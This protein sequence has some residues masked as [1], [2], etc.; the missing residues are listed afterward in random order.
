MIWNR[1]QNVEGGLYYFSAHFRVVAA[2]LVREIASRF[3][4]KPGGYVWALLEPAA[5]IGFLCMIFMSIAHKPAL[6]TNFPLFFATGYLAYQFYQASVVFVS[7]AVRVNHALL[8]YPNVAPIDTVV[9]RY[10][11]QF[12][13]TSFIAIV[14]L[15]LI[16]SMMGRPPEVRWAYVFEAAFAGSLLALGVAFF[17]NAAFARFP[18]YEQVFGIVSRPLFL[19]SGVFFLPDSMPHPY[20]DLL[21]YNP[22]AHIIMLFRKGFYPE[23]RAIGMDMGYIYT[24]A[25]VFLFVGLCMFTQASAIMRRK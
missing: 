4:N 9:A 21:L 12:G 13:T 1:G 6:G 19:M 15:S 18:A 7:S 11:L 3:G 24:I 20:R 2:L 23:Y 17:N 22:L 14:V 25:S 8:S 10:L 16:F 5:Y